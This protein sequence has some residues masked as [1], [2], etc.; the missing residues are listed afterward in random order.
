MPDAQVIPFGGG[1]GDRRA[2]RADGRTGSRAQ[3]RAGSPAGADSS[4]GEVPV[5]DVPRRSAEHR[6]H[7][8][9]L[10]GRAG[11]ESDG[12]AEGPAEESAPGDGATV[13]DLVAM[14]DQMA[15]ELLGGDWEQRLADLFAWLRRRLSGAYSVDEFGFDPELN[16]LFMTLL[17]P[18]YERYFRVETRG[19]EHIPAKGGALV[20][21]NHSGTVPLD[22]LMTQLA[23]ADHHPTG[24]HLRMLGADLLY[25]MPFLGEVARKSGHTLACNAD[26]ERM[27]G[28]GE[29]VGV[30]PE[31]YKGIGKTFGER[32]RLQRF[33]RGGFVSAALRTR[34]PIVPVSIVGAE[35]IYPMLGNLKTLA[36]LIGVPYIPI[37]PTFPWLGPLGA[38]PLPSRWIIEFGAPIR[39]DG[40]PPGAADDPMLVFDLTDRVRETIQHTLY[41]L[42][43]Q[44]RSVFF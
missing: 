31:G 17:R 39:T 15:T 10:T 35:E 18:M 9:N 19:L 32:Y 21:S 7:R 11:E 24:R 3:G 34:V 41:K 29:I 25:A 6:E 27:L 14:L 16:Q 44:R 2:R 30:W 43:M 37:T 4:E 38:I 1:D 40:Y 8:A 28:Q 23:L 42:L 20:V 22:A 36:R 12:P 33:G 26:A 5:R 13:H